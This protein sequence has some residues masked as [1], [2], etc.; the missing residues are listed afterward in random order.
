[1]A[2]DGAVYPRVAASPTVSSIR[3]LSPYAGYLVRRPT[4]DRRGAS[5]A[6]AAR[7]AGGDDDLGAVLLVGLS[8]LAVWVASAGLIRN[9]Y[10]R[11]AL[12]ALTVLARRQRP[13]DGRL[14]RLRAL[15][16]RL[17]DLLAAALAAGD[18]RGALPSARLLILPHR[19]QHPR[20]SGSS[21]RW[22]RCAR[23]PP[24]TAATG[25]IVGAYATGA[26]RSRSPVPAPTAKRRS[27][28]S[29]AATSR[30]TYVQRVVDGAPWPRTGRRRLEPTRAGPFLIALLAAP[31]RPRLVGLA[32]RANSAAR[33]FAA[34]RDPDL[35]ADVRRLRL[36]A[37]GRD[38]RWCG[39]RATYNAATAAATRSSR[40]CCSSAPP[41]SWS[42]AGRDAAGKPAAWVAGWR[43]RRCAR[44]SPSSPP[45]ACDANR[46]PW[47]PR[48]A[49]DALRRR[50]ARRMRG[51]EERE[52]GSRCRPRRQEWTVAVPCQSS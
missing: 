24:A 27:N 20:R 44:R 4:T 31:S 32:L 16:H 49:R 36:P 21:R 43:R 29:G 30:T 39:S 28:R 14:R 42:T 12:V 33:Y 15:V 13:G 6:A 46:D 35:A 17:R 11:G 48:L 37:G 50:G 25:L 5:N 10:L 8:G 26:W 2:E 7:C 19:P 22:P 3:S 41:W 45:S 52:L 40:P 23:S 9:T 34:D 18:D 47:H 38:A 1:M 51:R